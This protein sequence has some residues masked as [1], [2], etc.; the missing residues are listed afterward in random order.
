MDKSNSRSSIKQTQ[1]QLANRLIEQGQSASYKKRRLFLE[2]E[3]AQDAEHEKQCTFTPTIVSKAARSKYFETSQNKRPSLGSEEFSFKPEINKRTGSL[4]KK[5]T[6]YSSSVSPF[7]RLYSR[8]N[9]KKALETIKVSTIPR[10]TIDLK[11]FIHRQEIREKIKKEK[12][13]LTI[14]NTQVNVAPSI[15]E[16][17]KKLAAKLGD[18][19]TRMRV[20][21]LKLEASDTVGKDWFHP[22]INSKISYNLTSYVPSTD[23]NK[24]FSNTVVEK[25]TVRP[26]QYKNVQSKLKLNTDINTLVTRIKSEKELKEKT[27][28]QERQVKNIEEELRCTYKPTISS[29]PNYLT[30]NNRSKQKI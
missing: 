10:A 21:R 19:D 6:S 15:N 23:R 12:I 22:K 29:I 11:Q 9:S 2:R 20:Q 24:K 17:S 8:K 13:E 30:T 14:K 16:K 4:L 25:V 7:E 3:I 1:E 28:N 26:S 27:N 18:F 5:N